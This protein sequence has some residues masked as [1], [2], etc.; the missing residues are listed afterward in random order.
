MLGNLINIFNGSFPLTISIYI[1]LMLAVV[2]VTTLL[3]KLCLVL[4]EK[5]HL[6]DGVVAGII[7]G[8]I[9]SLPE[10]VT[11]LT[12]V[13]ENKNGQMGI[14]D[15]VG[16]NSF[17]L[18]V[19]AC[20]L[21]ACI[22]IFI[23]KKVNKINISSLICTGIGTLFVFFAALFG[24]NTEM[25]IFKGTTSPLVWHGFNFFSIPIFLSYCLAVY[26]MI[27]SSNQK[28]ANKNEGLTEL[29][30]AKKSIFHKLDLWILILLIVLVA[31]ILI[32]VSV[33]L[34]CSSTSLIKKWWGMDQGFGGALLLGVVT[35]LPEIV[36]C[37]N[38]C[39]HKEYNM[40]IDT[41]VGST[42]FNLSI[43]SISNI[44]LACVYN[45]KHTTTDKQIMYEFNV[46][47]IS[48]MVTGFLTIAFCVT[49]LLLNTEKMKKKF[50]R[51]QQLTINS[52]TL[53]L[54]IIPFIVF[55]VLGFIFNKQL[56]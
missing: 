42:A 40:T 16:S 19:L 41:M 12:A 5:A 27:K 48:Q 4:K 36:A 25:G 50:N 10:L 20:C 14:G 30:Q 32:T 35:S 18:F 38:L 52:I 17:D 29:K 1:V 6:S 56:H 7:I 21:F 33:L 51:K 43:L 28:P 22:W 3:S 31:L 49:Y 37:V 45:G 24:E 23:D 55:L 34:T 2:G 39:I 8:V 11:C 15:I 47:S 46:D 26:F 53:T 54:T 44:A 13:I 9:T